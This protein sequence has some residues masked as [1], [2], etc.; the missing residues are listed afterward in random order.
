[1]PWG[2]C[3]EG[4]SPANW[5]ILQGYYCGSLIKSLINNIQKINLKMEQRQ[6]THKSRAKI[7]GKGTKIYLCFTQNLL[8]I[9]F[10]LIKV[11]TKCNFLF[12]QHLFNRNI[13]WYEYIEFYQWQYFTRYFWYHSN[14]IKTAESMYG[15]LI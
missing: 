7:I 4:S 12:W 15:N 9:I 6:H 14:N 8:F 11:R 2:K 10:E 3:L 1:M 5:I 13:P